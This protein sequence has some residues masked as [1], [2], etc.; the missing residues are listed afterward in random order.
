MKRHKVYKTKHIKH[1]QKSQKKSV[2]RSKPLSRQKEMSAAALV[3]Q[4]ETNICSYIHHF[5][6]LFQ[7]YQKNNQKIQK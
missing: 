6:L 5:Y 3:K 2:S 7:N 4:R 1:F